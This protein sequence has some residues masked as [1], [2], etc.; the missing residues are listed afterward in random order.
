[1]GAYDRNDETTPQALETGSCPFYSALLDDVPDR[2]V[3]SKDVR[4]SQDAEAQQS[5]P[6]RNPA[7]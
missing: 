7:E 5:L 3:T 4:L 6:R 2:G 1:V